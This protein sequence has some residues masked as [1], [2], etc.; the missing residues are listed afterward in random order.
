[1]QEKKCP[2]DSWKETKGMSKEETQ[3]SLHSGQVRHTQGSLVGEPT[4]GGGGGRLALATRGSRSSR[5][6]PSLARQNPLT[7]ILCW[8][9]AELQRRTFSTSPDSR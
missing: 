1:M 7:C 8:C 4:A 2:K 3:M 9:S 6:L 5:T